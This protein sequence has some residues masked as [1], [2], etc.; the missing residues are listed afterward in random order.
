[1][2]GVGNAIQNMVA[3]CTV[4]LSNASGKLQQLQIR[5]LAGEVKSGVEHME[6]YGFTS[7]PLA[8][9]EGIAIF[10]GGDRSVGYVIV[11]ADRR[12]R[13][14]GLEPGELAIYTHEGAF[15]KLKNG[16]V[17]D[18]DCDEYNVK[19]KKITMTAEQQMLSA[20]TLTINA[21][22][23]ASSGKIT[24]PDIVLADTS[25]VTHIH[26]EHDGPSTSTPI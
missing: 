6:P 5:L 16:R 22:N 7:N 2:M 24:A 26:K 23:V 19:A 9:A 4:A 12:Y 11:T 20:T 3:R 17:I 18:V 15:I 1:M 8:G 21:A 14:S 13:I 25:M 10:P